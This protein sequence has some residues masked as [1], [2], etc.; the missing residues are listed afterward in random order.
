MAQTCEIET[1]TK[2]EKKEKK[3]GVEE[4]SFLKKME[5]HTWRNMETV[6]SIKLVEHWALG[7]DAG[8]D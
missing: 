8:S 4:N 7:C 3:N 1:K 6:L 5:K 2:K